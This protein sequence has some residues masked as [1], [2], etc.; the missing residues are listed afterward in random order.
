MT[1]SEN[2]RKIIQRSR[3]QAVKAV[4]K[5]VPDDLSK[6]SEEIDKIESEKPSNWVPK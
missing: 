4:E 6:A 2:L 3:N 5:I 1:N